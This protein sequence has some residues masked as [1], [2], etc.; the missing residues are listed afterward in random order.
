MTR[1]ALLLGLCLAAPA[2]ALPPTNNATTIQPSEIKNAACDFGVPI[3]TVVSYAVILRAGTDA[4]CTT[5][6]TEYGSGAKSCSPVGLITVPTISGTEAHFTLTPSGK[7]GTYQVVIVVEDAGGQRFSCDG[8][9]T[10]ETARV[11]V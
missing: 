11:T 9:V 4:A 2:W 3:E 5:A 10:V 1:T 8:K 7:R 6:A